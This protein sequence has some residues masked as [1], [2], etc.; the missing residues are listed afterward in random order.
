MGVIQI[1]TCGKFQDEIV[2]NS[3]RQILINNAYEREISR[4]GLCSICCKS[5]G[6]HPKRCNL[7]IQQLLDKPALANK[8]N[9]KAC[10]ISIGYH[11]N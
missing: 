3:Y 9:C 6:D 2:L 1:R 4:I 5:H 11:K 8:A 7:T 10:G